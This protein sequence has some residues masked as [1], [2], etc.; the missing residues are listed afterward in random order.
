MNILTN[1]NG[2]PVYETV[3]ADSL[4]EETVAPASEE[5][6]EGEDDGSELP[7]MLPEDAGINEPT[8]E[9]P[10]SEEA[11]SEEEETQ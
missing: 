7:Y 8:A 5:Y 4:D 1:S 3:S 2:E 9:I 6:I 11:P 10:T